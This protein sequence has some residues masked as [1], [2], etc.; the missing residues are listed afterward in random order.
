MYLGNYKNQIFRHYRSKIAIDS[1]R[2]QS[3]VEPTPTGGLLNFKTSEQVRAPVTAN[4]REVIRHR[5]P[6]I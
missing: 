3:T 5:S 4:Q 1:S 6:S 2:G